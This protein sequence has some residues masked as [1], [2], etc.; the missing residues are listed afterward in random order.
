M[1]TI[2]YNGNPITQS[3]SDTLFNL[4]YIDLSKRNYFEDLE[5]ILC[6]SDGT[7]ITSLKDAYNIKLN[8][9]L[10]DIDELEFDMPYYIEKQYTQVKNYNWDETEDYLLI[11]LNNKAVFVINSIIENGDET[12]TKHVHAYNKEYLLS[13]RKLPLLQGTKQLYKDGSETA[14]SKVSYSLDGVNWVDYTASF[15]TEDGKNVFIRRYDHFNTLIGSYVWNNKDKFAQ[16]EGLDVTY[17]DTDIYNKTIE[18]AIRIVSETGEGLLN[19]LEQETSWKIGYIDA[20]VREDRSL[21]QNHRKYRT[22]DISNQSWS[23][24]LYKTIPEL[25]NCIVRIDSLNQT[26]NIYDI[27]KFSENKGLYISKENYLKNIKKDLKNDDVITRL[28]VYGKDNLGISSI[29]PTG[30][31]FIEDFSYYRNSKYMDADLLQA[32]NN[33]DN[34]KTTKGLQFNSYLQQITN[35]TDEK[36]VLENELVD[37]QMQKLQ[38]EDERDTAIQHTSYHINYDTDINDIDI[39]FSD[40]HGTNLSTYNAEIA[41]I[42]ALINSKENEIENIEDDINIILVNIETLRNELD[43]KN[44]FTTEQLKVLNDFVREGFW[45][46]GNYSDVYELFTAGE[47]ALSK[48]SKPSVEFSIGIIDFLNVVECQHDWDKLNIGDTINIYYDDFDLYVEAKIIKISHDIDNNNIE[49]TVS[50]SNELDDDAKYISDLIKNSTEANSTINAFKHQWDLSGK[51]TDLI[52]EIISSGLDATKNRISSARNQN[53]T[54]DERGIGMKDLFDN[55]EQLRIVNNCLAMTIDSWQNVNLAITPR[56]IIA[57]QLYGKIIG[58][59]KLIITNMNESGE[60]SFIVDG[61]HMKAINMDLSLE[62]LAHTNKIYINPDTGIQIQRFLDGQWKNTMWLE[63]DGT[64]W[65]EWLKARNIEIITSNNDTLIKDGEFH[66]ENFDKMLSDGVITPLEK[67]SLRKEWLR[68][69]VEYPKIIIQADKYNRVDRDD[70]STDHANKTSLV[71]AYN[72]LYDLI[73]VQY[74][75]F[76][77]MTTSTNLTDAQKNELTDAFNDYYDKANK[78]LGL[79]EDSLEFSSL[80][81]GRYYNHVIMDD[82]NGIVVEKVDGSNDVWAR[83][84]LNATTGISIES[85]NP[86]SGS[87]EQSFWV[88]MNGYLYAKNLTILDENGNPA[89]N[90]NDKGELDLEGRLRVVRYDGLSKILLAD[91]YKDEQKGGKL[92]V[93]D[94]NGNSNI[95]LGSA[96]STDYTGGFFKLYNG[97]DGLSQERIEMGVLSPQDTGIIRLKNK[98]SN[99]IIE[100]KA[101][102]LDIGKISINNPLNNNPILTIGGNNLGGYVGIFGNTEGSINARFGVVENGIYDLVGGYLELY[103]GDIDSIRVRMGTKTDDNAGSISLFSSDN[104]E[105][106]IMSAIDDDMQSSGVIKLYNATNIPT[107]LM[108][109]ETPL[110]I[111]GREGSIDS[112]F[113]L[114]QDKEHAKVG[115]YGGGNNT[116]A[117][118]ELASGGI[119]SHGSFPNLSLGDLS[120]NGSYLGGNIVIY[121]NMQSNTSA[122]RIS[123]RRIQLGVFNDDSGGTRGEIRF[124]N[125]SGVLVGTVTGGTVE[126]HIVVTGAFRGSSSFSG[127]SGRFISCNIGNTNY[128]PVI[129]P[130]GNPNG[131]LGEVWII[132]ANNG[133]TVYNSGTATSSFDYTIIR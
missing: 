106:V 27:D 129:T 21:G 75:L 53:I 24:I 61:N 89:F 40:I 12:Q 20:D 9:Y 8:L 121:E 126:D 92:L 124:F 95:W 35:L 128:T 83:T 26:I 85:I 71:N 46:N 123:K 1:D 18:V 31:E 48:L 84:T 115:M 100:L 58:S 104:K 68:I 43:K 130:T 52:S 16:I 10:H 70:N 94:W 49:I 112:A 11:K 29:N 111:S 2:Y 63:S 65:T 133:F 103:N 105:K 80:Q 23:D 13:F 97:V 44:N 34:L 45:E 107:L 102:A 3:Q 17:Q 51:N 60:S 67:M 109:A 119:N 39:D 30:E 7:E 55:N 4:G 77:D 127:T 62:N 108:Y 110:N 113:V 66:L 19:L 36:T 79:I 88:G 54:I 59:N 117:L 33:Y 93:N 41:R 6:K 76:D 118:L 57:E 14:T 56:G 86:L 73:E 5:L 74:N 90:A 78:I 15:T 96:P 98:N 38:K 131:Y 25:F 22:F 99:P 91:L 120:R 28:R 50:N 81:L 87:M 122:E 114:G 82:T 64:L 125:N 69:Q 42:Q 116:G 132:K 72:H 101:D 32:L 37:L 47:Q